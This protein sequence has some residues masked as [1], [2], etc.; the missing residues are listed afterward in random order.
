MKGLR[1]KRDRVWNKKDRLKD[2]TRI[3]DTA[4]ENILNVRE[5]LP[6]LFGA[7]KGQ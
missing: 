1:N 4:P 5:I 7:I 6:S 2:Y 3:K